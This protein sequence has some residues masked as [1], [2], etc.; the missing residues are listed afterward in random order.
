[1]ADRPH[2]ELERLTREAGFREVRVPRLGEIG[3]LI[4][5]QP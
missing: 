2:E 3:Q 5:A 4:A 1:V